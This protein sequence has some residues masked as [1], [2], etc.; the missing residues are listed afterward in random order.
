MKGINSLMLIGVLLVSAV[1][2]P[3][4]SVRVSYA[5]TGE[6]RN[7][8]KVKTERLLEILVR[9]REHLDMVIERL[10]S[11]GL[12]LPSEAKKQ[13]SEAVSQAQEAVSISQAG[14]PDTA[15]K[16]ALEALKRLKN[17]L[18]RI[19]KAIEA[20]ERSGVVGKNS[21]SKLDGKSTEEAEKALG[22]RRA[23]EQAQIY[24]TKLR[25]LAEAAKSRGLSVTKIEEELKL[26]ESHLSEALAKFQSGQLPNATKELSE[27]RRIMSKT[28]GDLHQLQKPERTEHAERF[29]VKSVEQLTDMQKQISTLPIPDDVKS[30]IIQALEA[31]KQRVLE[32]RGLIGTLNTT[33]TAKKLTDLLN[34]REKALKDLEKERP[35]IKEVL[36]KISEREHRIENL[37]ARIKNLQS[38]REALAKYQEALSKA[39]KL[40]QEA[41]AELKD[42]DLKAA[43]EALDAADHILAEVSRALDGLPDNATNTLRAM[44]AV[45]AS[46][47][48]LIMQLESFPSNVDISKYKEGI[49]KVEELIKE[50]KHILAEDKNSDV[51][52]Q[53]TEARSTIERIWHNIRENPET[54]IYL[55][56]TSIQQ[57]IEKLMKQ[58]KELAN[59]TKAAEYGKKLSEARDALKEAVEKAGK[60]DLRGASATVE[61]AA[62]I[63]EKISR[64]VANELRE[65]SRQGK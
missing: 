2:V 11:R 56:I 20:A 38:S 18:D 47:K 26:A 13:I 48:T 10:E 3:M 60:G 6:D 35:N 61:R 31:A 52:K 24:L 16:L 29:I 1:L 41:K 9:A 5:Q 30:R 25:D 37:L 34:A 15:V 22:L 50:A 46:L 40:L 12:E 59:R 44:A 64:A 58:V 43:S 23:I 62:E 63:V 33:A 57:V 8:T 32:M 51:S 4:A 19:E 55:K 17:A 14:D 49:S 21:D 27:A 39:F 42:G 28:T 54:A 36:V 65:K 45:E 7:G 53:L